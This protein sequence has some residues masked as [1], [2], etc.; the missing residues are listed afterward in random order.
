M[1]VR[2]M[3]FKRCLIRFFIGII[4]SIWNVI[5]INSGVRKM[6]SQSLYSQFRHRFQMENPSLIDHQSLKTNYFI[7]DLKKQSL[8]I[9]I[10][11]DHEKG[12]N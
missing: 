4:F 12:L 11:E 5:E 9:V 2:A 7:L 3:N 8:F 1:Q 6:T 10:K